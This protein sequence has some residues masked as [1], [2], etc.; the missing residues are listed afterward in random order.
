M[1]SNRVSAKHRCDSL[2]SVEVVV[3]RVYR[4]S[5]FHRA[6]P[7]DSQISRTAARATAGTVIAQPPER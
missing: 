4:R 2:P 6:M 7:V 1:R 3:H 5:R